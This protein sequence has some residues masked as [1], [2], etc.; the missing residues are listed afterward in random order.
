ML[1]SLTIR[2]SL[3]QLSHS[4]HMARGPCRRKASDNQ[5]TWYGV[6][7]RGSVFESHAGC[8]QGN[9]RLYTGTLSYLEAGLCEFDLWG[10]EMSIC[11]CIY[12]SVWRRIRRMLAFL[13][14]VMIIDH[15]TTLNQARCMANYRQPSVPIRGTMQTLG[16]QAR[17]EV[18]SI[19]SATS[20]VPPPYPKLIG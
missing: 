6:G 12:T 3:Q 9:L 11:P 5:T 8:Q 19:Y 17:V 1:T 7:R 10:T 20:V 13:H 2:L 14:L 18:P 15:H 16:L 4:S